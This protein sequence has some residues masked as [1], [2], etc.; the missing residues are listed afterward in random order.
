MGNLPQVRIA[1]AQ[2]PMRP[3]INSMSTANAAQQALIAGVINIVLGT[4]FLTVGAT[5]CA[6]AAIRWHR[7]SSHP[8]MVGN[9]QWALRLPK[10]RTHADH[11]RGPAALVDVGRPHSE[12]GQSRI[13]PAAVESLQRRKSR[14][15]SRAVP[16][17]MGRNLRS[18]AELAIGP[19][20]KSAAHGHLG[21]RANFRRILCSFQFFYF[22]NFFTF[23]G[24]SSKS[25]YPSNFALS[26]S[27][28]C[29]QSHESV[30]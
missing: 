14:T 28:R 30:T 1:A 13:C 12:A 8:V 4:V 25:L 5:A 27:E 3:A 20:S 19:P 9:F 16:N 29:F 24:I 17:F 2:L 21:S 22:P 10:T 7:G 6:I 11:S 15:I 18:K 26:D 23:A